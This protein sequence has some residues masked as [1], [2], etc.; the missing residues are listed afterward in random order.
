M[1]GLNAP[2]N[3]AFDRLQRLLLAMRAGDELEPRDAA[4]LTGL[5]EPMC[6]TVLEGLSRVGLMSQEGADRFVRRHLESAL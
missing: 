5:A 6:R 3:D 4:R 1:N 2:L